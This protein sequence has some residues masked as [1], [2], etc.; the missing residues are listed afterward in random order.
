M[1]ARCIAGSFLLRAAASAAAA[2]IAFYLADLEHVHPGIRGSLIIGLASTLFFLSE[3][4]PTWWWDRC[5][6]W[7]SKSSRLAWHR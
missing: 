5:R 7:C 1:I 3:I 6:R 4:R 2:L